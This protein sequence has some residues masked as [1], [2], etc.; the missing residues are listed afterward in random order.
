M[1]RTSPCVIG[2]LLY[3][4]IMVHSGILLESAEISVAF[5]DLTKAPTS[6]TD[7]A[8]HDSQSLSVSEA[9]SRIIDKG[10]GDITVASSGCTIASAAQSGN[11]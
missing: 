7:K 9:F 10:V 5:D 6:V 11:K 1:K 2:A 8:N 3:L 4:P